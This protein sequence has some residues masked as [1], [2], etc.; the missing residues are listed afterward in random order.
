M[1]KSLFTLKIIFY[2][3][4]TTTLVF[5]Q[6]KPNNEALIVVNGNMVHNDIIKIIAE[7]S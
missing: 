7:Y 4:F 3:L 6:E 5:G 2:F 1:L